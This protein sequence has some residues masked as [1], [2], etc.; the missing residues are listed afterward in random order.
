MPGERTPTRIGIMSSLE[1]PK[2]WRRVGARA[3][4]SD[5]PAEQPVL[6]QRSRV[7][8]V[9]LGMPNSSSW[10]PTMT[11]TTMRTAVEDAADAGA[12]MNPAASR[13]TDNFVFLSY[14]SPLEH[15]SQ[16]VHFCCISHQ[17]GRI[18]MSCC[19][20]IYYL[21]YA[22]RDRMERTVIYGLVMPRLAIYEVLCIG[23]VPIRT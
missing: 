12:P 13:T 1:P 11:T 9:G 21:D 23:R 14:K 22:M 18:D 2:Q 3:P 20:A 7:T 4:G 15:T 17:C 16:F 8:T 6:S 10:R 19:I 5:S